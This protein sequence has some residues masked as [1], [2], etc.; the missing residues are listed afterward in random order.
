MF[1][2]YRN[3]QI[4]V[5]TYGKGPSIVLLH[6]FLL[7]SSIWVDLIPELSK[8]NKVITIDLPGH[9]KSECVSEIHS[10]EVMRD[11]VYSILEK[12]KIEK[13]SFIGHS[14]GGYVALAFAEKYPSK[15]ETFV[16]LNSSTYSDSLERK[17]NRDQAVK[18]IQTH[19]KVFIKMAIATLFPEKEHKKH[20]RLIDAF[21]EEAFLFPTEGIIASIKGMKN[22]LDRS[23]IL[24]KIK[25][26]KYMISGINDSIIPF[27]ISEKN[28]LETKVM[29]YK[30][31]SGHMSVNE[32]IS[33][34][35]KIMYFINF[36]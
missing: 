15:T 25:G 18:I 27:S 24:K 21:S 30:V 32:N 33:K 31:N 17:K 11:V 20:Q 16:L 10:M 22:R 35:V 8:K 29:L 19:K 3:S 34:I 2:K 4:Y 6:G 36:L 14:M 5:K 28:A 7:S 13:A 12:L 9:G 23:A 26:K 1:I